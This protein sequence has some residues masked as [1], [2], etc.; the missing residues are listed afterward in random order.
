MYVNASSLFA[1]MFV[2]AA[3]GAVA[4]H[5]AKRSDLMGEA[6][7][8]GAI[9][10]PVIVVLTEGVDAIADEDKSDAFEAVEGF[11]S[12]VNSGDVD[13]AIEAKKRLEYAL[14]AFTVTA[15]AKAD[16]A[17]QIAGLLNV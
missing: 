4:A 7:L 12:A 11:R 9:L 13:D 1:S 10:G 16:T 8:G 2:G 17:K 3:A 15:K 14:L 5:L 6:A